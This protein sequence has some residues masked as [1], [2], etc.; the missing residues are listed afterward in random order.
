MTT[1]HLAI[2]ALATFA[3][4]VIITSLMGG[5]DERRVPGAYREMDRDGYFPPDDAQ[6]AYDAHTTD[7]GA[8]DARDAS[9]RWRD[10]KPRKRSSH[11]AR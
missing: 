2:G 5:S 9:K 4:V 3:V 6:D 11:P 7:T 10:D 1:L 8:T